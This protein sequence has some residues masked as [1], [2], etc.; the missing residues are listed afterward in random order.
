MG[1]G[2]GSYGEGMEGEGAVPQSRCVEAPWLFAHVLFCW[3]MLPASAVL[4]HAVHVAVSSSAGTWC[5]LRC[6]I[7]G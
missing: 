4:E 3:G 6:A 2:A 1:H 5:P 7:G